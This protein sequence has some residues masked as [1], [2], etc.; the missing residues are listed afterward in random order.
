MSFD[1]AIVG[2]GYSGLWTAYYLKT[3]EPSLKIAVFDAKFAG[4]G[5]SGRN[6]GW[7]S[8]LFSSSLQSLADRFSPL[9]A[10]NLY[11]ELHNS[12]VEIEKVTRANDINAD[13]HKGGT[14]TV[15]RNFQ[16][17]TRAKET[18]NEYK[19]FGFDTYS[20][21]DQGKV[22]DRISVPSAVGGI[23]TAECAR[24]QPA[25]LVRGLAEVIEGLGVEI[26]EQSFATD[27]ARN[28]LKVNGNRIEAEVIVE[29]TEGYRSRIKGSKRR[30]IPIY[31]LMIATRRLTNSEIQSVGLSDY[32]TFADERHLVIYGQRSSDDRIVFGGRGAPY[33]FGSKVHPNFDDEEAIFS[34]LKE[35]LYDLIPSLRG[36]DI[37]YR[38]GGALGVPRD[39]LSFVEFDGTNYARLGGYVGDGV[40]TSNLSARTLADLITGR[41][42]AL[43][44]LPIVNPKSRNWEVEPL[45]AIGVNLGIQGT[46]RKDILE[47][48][49][50]SGDFFTRIADSL[51]KN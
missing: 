16:Q 17:L 36:I 45:R 5:A 51:M 4:F 19:R 22:Q 10:V 13:F 1:V 14:I 50:K 40:T 20:L 49:G 7:A 24:I 21:L 18:I 26:F 46:M 39:F 8:T 3:I 48:Q 28:Q 33:H 29:A 41:Q 35:T 32:E 30:T 43:T 15:A 31:S 12:L 42:S 23:Y 47:K 25:K 11:N 44:T 38:W 34:L 37:E 9:D 2:G 6:G 27:I